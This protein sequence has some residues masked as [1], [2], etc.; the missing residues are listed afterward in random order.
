[1]DIVSIMKDSLKYPFSDW[2]KFLIFGIILV[3]TNMFSITSLCTDDLTL[4]FGSLVLG[5]IIGFLAKGYLFRIIKSSTTS[6]DELPEFNAWGS[7]FKDGIKVLLVG[8]VYVIIPVFL[9]VIFGLFLLE[10]FGDL[11]LNLGGTL[12]TSV[13]LGFG[14]DFLVL[15]A[16]LY[17]I[18][19]IPITLVAMANM[20]CN[21]SKLSA[22]FSFHEIFSKI[23]EMGWKNLILWYITVGI[24][25]LVLLVIDIGLG[26]LLNLIILKLCFLLI[27]VIAATYLY[28]Y[29]ARSLGLIYNAHVDRDKLDKKIISVGIIGVIGILGM[30]LVVLMVPFAP[31]TTESYGGTAVSENTTILIIPDETTIPVVTDL[32]NGSYQ[33]TGLMRSYADSDYINVGIRVRG[34]DVNGNEITEKE[35]LIAKIKANETSQYTVILTPKKGEVVSSADG[36]V[37]NGTAA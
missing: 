12:S 28:I 19:I 36:T 24:P 35:G 11:I 14:I 13:T 31:I 2:K 26:L 10:I 27:S 3:F 34:Y 21:D 22:A 17:L 18:S 25:F 6:E 5:F 23:R 1:M 32:K 30:I 20:A 9:I 37:L 7:M 4:A 29:V 8:L 15:I 16:I 33:V